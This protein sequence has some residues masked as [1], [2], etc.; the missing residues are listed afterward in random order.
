VPDNAQAD[1]GAYIYYPVHDLLNLL[2]LESQRNQCLVIGED[3][4]TV[5]EGIEQ[6]LEDAGV[7]SYKV[8]F[9]E[10]ANDGGYISPAHYKKQAMA[11]LSTHD[12]PTIK[13]YWHSEDLHLGKA[14]GL[15]PDKQVLDKLMENR[16]YCKQQILNS[17]HGHGSLPDN[18]CRDATQTGMDK[19]LNFSMQTHLAKGKAMLLSLQLED[20]LEME[21]PVNVPGTSNEYRNWQRKLSQNIEQLFSNEQIQYLFENLTTARKEAS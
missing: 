6:L 19:T 18:Y 21:E 9:F 4:G 20:F 7:Y 3:L 11:T 16:I 8:F 15:Y 14:L 12:M 2:S 10:Q 17:L 5:P 13:G 1:A